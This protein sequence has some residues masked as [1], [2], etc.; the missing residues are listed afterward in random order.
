MKRRNEKQLD[1]V[2]RFSRSLIESLRALDD[3]TLRAALAP[4]ALS[5]KE[6]RQLVARRDALL[7]HVDALIDH[8]GDDAVLCFE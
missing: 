5:D 4:A 7:A 8:E 1:G 2:S 6:L 3:D